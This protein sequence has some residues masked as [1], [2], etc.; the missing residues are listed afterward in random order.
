MVKGEEKRAVFIGPRYI[1]IGNIIK[2][3][4]N[5]L[6]KKVPSKPFVDKWVN[7]IG[8]VDNVYKEIRKLYVPNVGETDTEV[9]I[10]W[11]D[12]HLKDYSPQAHPETI[13][14]IEHLKSENA[15][16]KLKINRILNM[17][18]DSENTD[19]NKKKLKDE[20]EYINKIKSPYLGNEGGMGGGFTGSPFNRF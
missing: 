1:S 17:V 6:F 18:Y 16:L 3:G 4:K 11:C 12:L 7:V 13:A 2:D 15:M 14:E 5:I 10:Y 20:I 9:E 19:L 8:N